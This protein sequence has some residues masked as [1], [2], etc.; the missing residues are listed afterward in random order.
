MSESDVALNNRLDPSNPNR[1]ERQYPQTWQVSAIYNDG[2]IAN[3]RAQA[4]QEVA[5]LNGGGIQSV[6]NVQNQSRQ[7]VQST[8]PS[9]T[10]RVPTGLYP[11]NQGELAQPIPLGWAPVQGATSYKVTVKDQTTG[12]F[13]VDEVTV[14]SI[15]YEVRVAAGRTFTWDVMAC[16]QLGC[17][18]PSANVQFRTGGGNITAATYDNTLNA[19][20]RE[21]FF[22]YF[23]Y[24]KAQP[25]GYSFA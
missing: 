11:T 25:N 9:V 4:S 3:W 15:P 1:I 17:S 10:P 20:E 5:R 21:W 7:P 24:L 19:Q 18:A 16:N 13:P 12:R 22:A 2:R 23:E 14:T 6:G 8:Q